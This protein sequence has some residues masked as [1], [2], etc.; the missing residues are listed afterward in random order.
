[1][2]EAANPYGDGHAAKRTVDAIAQWFEV[3]GAGTFEPFTPA[4]ER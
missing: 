3:P 2:A 1:M 4:D